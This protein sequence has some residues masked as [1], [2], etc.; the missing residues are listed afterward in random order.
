[1]TCLAR[2]G[3]SRV[4]YVVRLRRSTYSSRCVNRVY[5]VGRL[6]DKIRGPPFRR[7]QFRFCFFLAPQIG[8]V[9]RTV[10]FLKP[11]PRLCTDARHVITG[12]RP[13][14]AASAEKKLWLK[15]KFA[16]RGVKKATAS[17]FYPRARKFRFCVAAATICQNI[18]L[19]VKKGVEN[20]PNWQKLSKKGGNS[21]STFL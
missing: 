9:R 5:A 12:A 15:S 6:A 11:I 4:K 1:M 17:F 19:L 2:F 3:I 16:P 10:L 20:R 7:P 13:R 14:F 18:L 8:L 21:T